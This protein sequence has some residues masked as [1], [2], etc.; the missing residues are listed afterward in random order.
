[1]DNFLEHNI[2]TFVMTVITVY[3]LFG[4]DIRILATNKYGDEYLRIKKNVNFSIKKKKKKNM[5]NFF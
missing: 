5:M 4:D 3:A 1:M 2:T